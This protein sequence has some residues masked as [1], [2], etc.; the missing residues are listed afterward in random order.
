M[1]GFSANAAIPQIA[2]VTFTDA[3]ATEMRERVR[4]E[5]LTRPELADHR[6][7]LDEAVIG[8]IHSLCRQLLRD[9]PVEAAIDPA[10]R[11]LSDDEAE[12]ELLTACVDALED[13]AGADDRRALALHEI[14][15]FALANQLPLMVARRD[16]V[17]EAYRAMPGAGPEQWAAHVQAL[18]DPLAQA[19][20]EEARP[21]IAEHAEWLQAAVDAATGSDA[22]YARAD[23]VLAALGDPNEGGWQ[24]LLARVSDAGAR[25]NL[26][27]G[28]RKN[29]SDLDGVKA[30]MGAIRDIASRLRGVP[31]WNEHDA[32]ALEA[33]ASLR[34]LFDDACARYAARRRSSR[35]STTW[36]WSSRRPSCSNR[37]R[38]WQLLTERGSA[39]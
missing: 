35:P 16:E 31:Q 18:L 17:A 20:I 24:E 7:S 14:G 25:V 37:I 32:P 5:V 2:A 39:I 26:Q 21:E 33:L 13:A 4:R 11:V 29:W 28:S 38:R 22:M 6:A 27:G 8:T 15:V 30:A 36:T 3:A 19:A 12:S 9:N 1:S 23:A 34:L 10:V